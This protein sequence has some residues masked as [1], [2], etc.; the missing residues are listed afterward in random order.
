MNM[1]FLV[2]I[3]ILDSYKSVGPAV[4]PFYITTR[5]QGQAIEALNTL[6]KQTDPNG[7]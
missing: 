6:I 7:P 3:S 5:C 1:K 2:I 4:M